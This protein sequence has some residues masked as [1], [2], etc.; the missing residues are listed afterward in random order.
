MS[1]L[2]GFSSISGLVSGFVTIDSGDTLN[3][4]KDL[5]QFLEMDRTRSSPGLGKPSVDFSSAISES[6]K[7]TL[8]KALDNPFDWLCLK[9]LFLSDSF[10]LHILPNFGVVKFSL[11]KLDVDLMLLS[12]GEDLYA[13]WGCRL[14]EDTEELSVL[15]CF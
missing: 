9:E 5:T 12:L 4:L 3:F 15:E 10:F 6:L 1:I 7:S 2:L 11:S 14:N 13:R 8:E